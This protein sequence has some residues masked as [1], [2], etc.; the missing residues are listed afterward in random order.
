MEIQTI[1]TPYPQTV[2]ETL[3]LLAQ[4][5]PYALKAVESVHLKSCLSG[6]METHF[7][8]EIP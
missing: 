2:Y 4:E 7:V 5:S 1:P 6:T 3:P 8:D